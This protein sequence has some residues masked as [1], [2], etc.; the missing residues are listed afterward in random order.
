MGTYYAV[1]GQYKSRDRYVTSSNEIAR[2]LVHSY[3]FNNRS[4]HV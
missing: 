1:I 2:A 4:L 3:A